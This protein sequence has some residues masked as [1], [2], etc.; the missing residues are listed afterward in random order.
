V[1]AGKIE[2]LACRVDT[3]LAEFG[4]PNVRLDRPHPEVLSGKW[5]FPEAQ[6][7]S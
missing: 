6:P 5:R 7:L 4:L 2:C 1:N 3:T